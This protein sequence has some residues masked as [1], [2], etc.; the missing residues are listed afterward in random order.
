MSNLLNVKSLEVLKKEFEKLNTDTILLVVDANV[1]NLY[2]KSFDF[3]NIKGKKV[4]IWKC[5]DGEETKD[6]DE[7]KHCLEF[8]L[9]KGVHRRSHLIAIGGGACS[10]FAGLVASMLLRGVH[11]SV[12]PTTLL[13]MI[14]ASIGGKVAI[15]SEY[16]KN[17]VGAFHLPDNIYIHQDF[18]DTLDSSNINSGRGE[19]LK[20][21]FLDK[22]IGK[23]ILDEHNF[24]EV[25]Q[26]CAKYKQQIV[27]ED[28]KESGKRKVLNLGHTVGH[29]LERI[30]NLPHGVA[31]A[32]GILVIFKMYDDSKNLIMLKEFSGKLSINLEQPPWHNK[33]FPIDD[34]MN[35]IRKDKKAVTS[36]E[37]D[38]IKIQE[39]G[40]PEIERIKFSEFEKNLSEKVDE[41]RKFIL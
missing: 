35:Y 23:M 7:L 16:G 2:R 21:C 14:D 26:S 25:I 9:S 18:L 37:L 39:I 3:L 34:I 11:W 19:L 36:E 27:E 8:F 1:Y 38:I 15:N 28:F 32:W 6:Y 20:Y 17:L 22:E 30:F 41:L 12:V 24:N 33:S 40:S 31:V 13:S 29:V 5:L 10:D 4:H